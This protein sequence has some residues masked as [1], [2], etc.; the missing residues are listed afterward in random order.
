MP[1]LYK[2]L[3]TTADLVSPKGSE[4]MT[5]SIMDD[6]AIFRLTRFTESN[7]NYPLI[8]KTNENLTEFTKFASLPKP[9]QNWEEWGDVRLFKYSGKYYVNAN[10]INWNRPN[11]PPIKQR[12]KLNSYTS[13]VS[14]LDI[15]DDFKE[16]EIC[17]L[18]W[19]DKYYVSPFQEKNYAFFEHENQLYFMR[20]I[21]DGIQYLYKL[22]L[23]TGHADFVNATK[24]ETK[25]PESKY[26]W[27]KICSTPF[28]YDNLFWATCH[29]HTN[30]HDQIPHPRT[31]Y[32]NYYT[33]I[34][35]FES[36]PPFKILKISQKPIFDYSIYYKNV[37]EHDFLKAKKGIMVWPSSLVIKND[38][39]QIGCTTLSTDHQDF[40]NFS[41]EEILKHLDEGVSYNYP[42]Q[43]FKGNFLYDLMSKK[44]NVQFGFNKGYD[45]LDD[46]SLPVELS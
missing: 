44:D 30:P 25:Y 31:L 27:V 43:M 12:N 41:Y 22:N 45:W 39:F 6:L 19:R 7:R 11:S 29:S 14:V 8:Y 2:T 38:I 1:E 35:C 46:M 40:I 9:P 36:K 15:E 33:G 37:S 24:Y 32:P 17:P 23:E 42:T 34:C 3:N 21:S 26:G 20:G 13:L 10:K 18:K 5:P 28:Y 4:P 16:T